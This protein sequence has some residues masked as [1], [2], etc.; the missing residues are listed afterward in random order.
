MKYQQILI[1]IIFLFLTS[2]TPISVTAIPSKTTM[3]LKGIMTPS[4]T[5]SSESVLKSI[6]PKDG[7]TMIYINEG[8]FL[9]GTTEDQAAFN[10][11]KCISDTKNTQPICE[12]FLK[13]EV[14]QH[15]VFLDAYWIDQTDITNEMYSKCVSNGVCRRPYEAYSHTRKGYYGNSLFNDYPVIYVDW[16]QAKSYCQWVGRRLPT[17]AEWEKA[18]RGTDGRTYPWGE[19]IDGW[20]A[21]YLGLN[22]TT[23]VNNHPD[24]VSPYE[25]Y[26]MAGNVSQWVADWYDETY[27]QSKLNWHNPIGCSGNYC[28]YNYPFKVIRG[29][30][31]NSGM[32]DVRSAFRFYASPSTVEDNIGFRCAASLI[33]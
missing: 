29:G 11:Q 15:K 30:G 3:P 16:D 4:P 8:E 21:N 26:D 33:P 2:C 14:P 23:P 6:S 24:G 31:W 7:M 25:I 28:F 10:I 32:Y 9:M 20:K 12:E 22:D 1:T 27:Y 17:E 18:A 5:P 13:G 19:G